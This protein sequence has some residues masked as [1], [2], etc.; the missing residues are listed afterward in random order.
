[1]LKEAANEWGIDAK[2]EMWKLPPMYVGPYAEQ[3]ARAT[4]DL[5]KTLKIEIVK[6]DL[7]YILDLELSLSIL[8]AFVFS[9]RS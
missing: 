4:L 5:W 6:T 3:D 8:G 1:M 2:G 9:V 7:T